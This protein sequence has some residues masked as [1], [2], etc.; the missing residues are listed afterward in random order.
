M[1]AVQRPMQTRRKCLSQPL[2][3]QGLRLTMAPHGLTCVPP[4]LLNDI[5]KQVRELNV[6]DDIVHKFGQNGPW[7]HLLNVKHESDYPYR[8]SVTVSDV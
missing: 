6:D 7:V 5:C 2:A 3:E 8:E 4:Q 1:P